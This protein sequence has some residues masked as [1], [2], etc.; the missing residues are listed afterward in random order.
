[1]RFHI[2]EEGPKKCSTTPE[3]CTVTVNGEKTEHFNTE[4]EAY[5]NYENFMKKETFKKP[6][7]KK[8]IKI[9]INNLNDKSWKN[10]KGFQG[11]KFDPYKS[12][13]ISEREQLMNESWEEME[14]LNPTEREAIMFY[15]S[16]SFK[17]FQRVLFRRVNVNSKNEENYKKIMQNLDSAIDKTEKKD[18]IV[19]RGM[20]GTA[21]ILASNFNDIDIDK[22]LEED[23][24]DFSDSYSEDFDLDIDENKKIND[25]VKNNLSLGKI[26]EFEG[27]QSTTYS[28]AVSSEYAEGGILFEI[29]T[30]EGLNI[31]SKSKF[32]QE[33]EVL[34]PRETKYA[35]VGVQK[36]TYQMTGAKYVVQ[37]IAVN[38]DNTIKTA[39][40][41][42]KNNKTTWDDLKKKPLNEPI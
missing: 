10:F 5:V 15:T 32:T 33:E 2:T 23:L 39:E 42:Q 26:I 4:Q 24:D 1:M 35:V 29:K 40:N 12:L 41:C 22:L 17:D 8:N 14:K 3:K 21:T 18:K 13:T 19:Y 30:P 27:Y 28:P 16:S 6:Q 34:L 38:D 31:K 36:D 7:C 11:L 20:H 25:Y 37:L 9:D